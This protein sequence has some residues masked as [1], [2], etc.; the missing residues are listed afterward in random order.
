MGRSMG[1][2]AAVLGVLGLVCSGLAARAEGTIPIAFIGPFSGPFGPQGDAFFKQL[3]YSLEAVNA[4]GGAL[5]KKF[6]MV[7]FDDKMQPAE[8]LIALKSATDRN[9]PFVLQC[10]GSNVAAAMSDGVSKY[11]ARNPDHR[12]I[13]LNCAAL[14]NE[15]TNEK[16]DFWHFRFADNVTQ[17][18]DMLV[19]GLPKS[20]R[21][22]YLINQDYLYGQSVQHELRGLLAQRR[23]DITVVGDE[24]V[25]LGKVK[26]FS[27]YIAKIKSSGAHAVLTSN[28]GT[29]F[30]QLLK[31]GVNSGI[32]VAYYTLSAHLNGGPTAMGPAGADRVHSVTDFH[33]N[34]PVEAHNAA[35]EAWISGFRAKNPDFDLVWINFRTMFEMLRKAITK[36]GSTDPMAVALAL[37]GIEADDVIGQ[38]NVMRAQDH[39]LLAPLTVAVFTKDVKYDSEKTGLGWKTELTVPAAA[40]APPTT[41]QMKRPAS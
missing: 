36:A 1:R 23:P 35:A 32:D 18:A 22:V 38:P 16:C 3:Q 30:N 26:D 15:L 40:L 20:V 17:R 9:I 25:P 11:N 8:S 6:E 34:L 5:G 41:C 39:Q 29:D 4:E 31:A 37:E 21:T 28:W 7:T 2:W 33:E 19:R 27:P 14:A 12:V 24:L 10:L 13:H